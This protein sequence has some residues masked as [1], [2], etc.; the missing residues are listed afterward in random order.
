MRFEKHNR[1][2]SYALFF[3]LERGLNQTGGSL[4]GMKLVEES[5][6]AI[7]RESFF[8]YA[9]LILPLIL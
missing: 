6:K 3:I 4:V 9:I 1:Q 7:F 5:G 2:R 8:V